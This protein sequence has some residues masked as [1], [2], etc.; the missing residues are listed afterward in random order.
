MVPDANQ[1][2]TI[3]FGPFELKLHSAELRREGQTIKLAPQPFKVLVLLAESSGRM[4]TRK[5][6]Q[7]KVWGTDT[8][9]DFDKGLNL[10]IAQI[11]DALGDD[12]QSPRF[13]ETLP[14]RGY[15]FIASVEKSVETPA[16]PLVYSE[17]REPSTDAR[18][19]DRKPGRRIFGID[20]TTVLGLSLIILV[21]AAVGSVYFRFPKIS[22]RPAAGTKSVLL[23]LPFENLTNDPSQDYFS[24]GLTEE[25]I[26]TLGSLQPKRLGVIARTTALTYKRSGK[27]I[28]QIGSELGVNYV[29]EGSV[30]R[31]AGRLRITSQLIQVDDQ[32][33]LWAETYDRNETDVLDI[34]REVALR[35]ASSLSFEL[36]P[37]S[38]AEA[39]AAKTTRPEAYDAYL[40][41]RYLITKDNL[42]DLE[43]SIPYFDR[44][45]AEDPNF[46]PAYAAEVEALVLIA[47]WTGTTTGSN[48]PKAKAAATKAIELNPSYAEAYAALGSVNFWLEWNWLDAEMNL[49]RALELNPNNPLTRVRFGEYLLARGRADE[50]AAQITEALKLDPVSLLTTGLAA[51][52]Q[53]HAGRYDDAIALSNRMLELE[54]KSPAA[55]ECLYRAYLG[56][57]K[58]PEAVDIT[59]RRMVLAGGKREDVESLSKRSPKDVIEAQFRE[60]LGQMEESAKKGERVWSMYLAWLYARAGR[61]DQA[62]EWLEKA[63]GERAPFLVYLNVDPAWDSLRSDPRFGHLNRLT[64]L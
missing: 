32:T 37:S 36:L 3:S 26:T 62:F 28:R 35:V 2:D 23:V 20:R 42:Q 31:E 53:L 16:R 21:A 57:G 46:A 47:D 7:E 25:M 64:A 22:S 60:D 27:D 30:R 13:I 49:R 48:L 15:R 10:C 52:A 6:L 34:Q 4:V 39:A 59:R 40:K 50:G 56:Q 8:F 18:D 44:A 24:D 41:G 33:H 51:F 17:S 11:R 38:Y 61:K 19:L 1:Y 29:L 14:R 43:R 9:V 55:H 54:P 63:L 5:E 12:A 45:I 58:Y